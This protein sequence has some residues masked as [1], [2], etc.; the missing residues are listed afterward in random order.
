MRL[1]S[2]NIFNI[3]ADGLSSLHPRPEGRGFTADR[4]KP[5]SLGQGHLLGK[6][7]KATKVQYYSN[8]AVLFTHPNSSFV[9]YVGMEV[10][11]EP[12]EQEILSD[13]KIFGNKVSKVIYKPQ[14]DLIEVHLDYVD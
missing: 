2:F 12:Q 10:Y 13:H 8:G 3:Q 7:M 9:P 5:C 11:L 14:Q 4:I 6:I 1:K